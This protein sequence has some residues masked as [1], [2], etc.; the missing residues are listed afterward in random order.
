[1]ILKMSNESKVDRTPR[2]PRMGPGHGPGM[3]GPGEKAKDFKSAIKRLFKE[4]KG[5][6]F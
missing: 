3:G 6:S 2:G 1:M 4:L 5:F